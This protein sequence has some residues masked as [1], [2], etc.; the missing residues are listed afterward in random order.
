MAVRKPLV[1]SSSNAPQELQAGDTLAFSALP[2][3]YGAWKRTNA[4]TPGGSGSYALFSASVTAI[5]TPVG[6][7]L[8]SDEFA[9]EA[10]AY[11]VNVEAY[12]T[13]ASACE[14]V[15][16]ADTGTPVEVIRVSKNVAAA[17]GVISVTA[18]VTMSSAGTINILG[19]IAT[20]STSVSW[21][22]NTHVSI[23]RVG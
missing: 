2:L 6:I 8:T 12:D 16:Q 20:M 3:A 5:D 14:V 15:I 7:S 22:A 10:G 13:G 9:V 23:L 21:S 4:L 19:D 18:V 11:L 1:L 17:P